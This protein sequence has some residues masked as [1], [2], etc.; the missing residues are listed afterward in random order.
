[1]QA[2]IARSEAGEDAHWGNRIGPIFCPMAV[3]NPDGSDIDPRSRLL[4]MHSFLAPKKV[5]LEP[6]ILAWVR[7]RIGQAIWDSRLVH[8]HVPD[9]LLSQLRSSAPHGSGHQHRREVDR[10]RYVLLADKPP[11]HGHLYRGVQRAGAAGLPLRPSWLHAHPDAV[12]ICKR[13]AVDGLH[14]HT[15]PTADA[16]P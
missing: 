13:I 16:L 8:Q 6:L 10:H 9:H 15:E 4:K 5:S 12:A 1:M 14:D 2:D 3:F 11:G 7:P